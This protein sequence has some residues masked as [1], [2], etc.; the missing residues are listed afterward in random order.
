MVVTIIKLS[1][2]AL[3]K[4][5]SRTYSIHKNFVSLST[6]LSWPTVLKIQY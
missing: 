5:P 2:G 3:V 6:F 4:S 1:S